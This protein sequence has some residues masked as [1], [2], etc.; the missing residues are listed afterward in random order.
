MDFRIFKEWLQGVKTHYIENF[1]I[2][3]ESSWNI[4]V[5]NE[6]AHCIWVFKTQV[7]AKRRAKNQLPIWL[8][9]T[10]SQESPWFNYVQ[11]ACDI[12]LESFGQELQLCFRPHFNRRSAQKIMGFH[13]HKSP[14]FENFRTPNLGV[15][16]Q[17]DIWVQ[18]PWPSIKNTIRGKVVVSSK[19]ELWWVLWVRVCMWLVHAPK[20]FQLHINQL[21][22]WFMQVHVNNWP[23]CH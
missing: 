11:V 21:V 23:T 17:N 12:L 7:M 1:F 18:A 15:P 9:T 13:N 20:M 10:K 22:V 14:N 8:P 16:G 4:D 2:P 19:S 5:W 3:F 6:L